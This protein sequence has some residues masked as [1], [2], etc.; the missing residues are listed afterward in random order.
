LSKPIGVWLTRR[1]SDRSRRP[2]AQG[3]GRAEGIF[4]CPTGQAGDFCG[5]FGLG[6]RES[7]FSGYGMVRRPKR[8][9]PRVIL[10][11][12]LARDLISK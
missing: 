10:H 9:R 12:Q 6:M 4:V 5:A 7:D 8:D 11:N 2:I 1:S 3:Q